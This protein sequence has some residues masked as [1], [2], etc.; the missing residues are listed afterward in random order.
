MMPNNARAVKSGFL[1]ER[2]YNG[3]K[4]HDGQFIS[5]V[6]SE[7]RP[8]LHIITKHAVKAKL[9]PDDGSGIN[10]LEVGIVADRG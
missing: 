10:V 9:A 6:V 3:G 4:P 5:T 8:G 7:D 2:A 1:D